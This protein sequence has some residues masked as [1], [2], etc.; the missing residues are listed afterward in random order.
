MP[1]GT[2]EPMKGQVPAG[3][4]YVGAIGTRLHWHR[5]SLQWLAC[6]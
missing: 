6:P 1:M 4:Q 3:I 2:G 5:L